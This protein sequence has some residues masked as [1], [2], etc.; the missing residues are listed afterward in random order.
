M[1]SNNY[2]DNGSMGYPPNSNAFR[3]SNNSTHKLPT[4]E[5]ES[6]SGINTNRSSRKNKALEDSSF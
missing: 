3:T 1:R 5:E 4:V 6:K 2:T